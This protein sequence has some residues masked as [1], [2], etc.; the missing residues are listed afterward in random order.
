MGYSGRVVSPSFTLVRQYRLKKL[1]LYHIDLYRLAGEELDTLGLD[2]YLRGPHSAVCI[3]WG[4]KAKNWL[5][6]HRLITFRYT[7]ETSR[8][9]SITKRAQ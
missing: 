9:I 7:G 3:E 2:E 6:E 8:T 5:A 1:T 4:A